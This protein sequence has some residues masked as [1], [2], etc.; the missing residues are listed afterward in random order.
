MADLGA[1]MT[2]VTQASKE[3]ASGT[4]CTFDVKNLHVPGNYL[5]LGKLCCANDKPRTRSRRA[6]MK[7]N[8]RLGSHGREVNLPTL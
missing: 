1:R 7:M 8:A 6:P 4:C 5:L 3:A 2:L